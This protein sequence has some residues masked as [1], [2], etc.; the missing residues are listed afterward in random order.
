M[1]RPRSSIG[2][3][4]GLRSRRLQVRLLS[5]ILAHS[6]SGRFKTLFLAARVA[7]I[8]EID[9]LAV[10]IDPGSDETKAVE[11][12]PGRLMSGA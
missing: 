1:I 5:G 10:A 3:S 4:V 7:Q 2:Q 6:A 12:G 11:L 8:I 9:V